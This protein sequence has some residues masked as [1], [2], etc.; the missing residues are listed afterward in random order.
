MVN[1]RES[2]GR[3]RLSAMARCSIVG[4]CIAVTEHWRLRMVS[5]HDSVDSAQS[6][7]SQQRWIL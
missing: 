3:S 6:L 1:A 4:G 5:V 2:V 7:K